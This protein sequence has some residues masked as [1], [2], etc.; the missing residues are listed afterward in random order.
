M[1]S[2]A[3]W[4]ATAIEKNIIA[5]VQFFVAWSLLYCIFSC[6]DRL[7]YHS[8]FFL[9][10]VE[11]FTNHI[12]K[13]TCFST[14]SRFCV[15]IGISKSTIQ[16]EWPSSSTSLKQAVPLLKRVSTSF[17][18]TLCFSISMSCMLEQFFLNSSLLEK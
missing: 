9:V 16:K 14:Y 17:Q 13:I 10:I 8:L 5:S 3:T 15:I 11:V 12:S 18:F 6:V 1:I 4:K 7:L 2:E